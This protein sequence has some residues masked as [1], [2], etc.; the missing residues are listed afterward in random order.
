[1]DGQRP[2]GTGDPDARLRGEGQLQ[3]IPVTML[4]LLAFLSEHPLNQSP[5]RHEPLIRKSW[6]AQGGLSHDLE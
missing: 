2:R 3:T 1:M 4:L 5:R 6:G